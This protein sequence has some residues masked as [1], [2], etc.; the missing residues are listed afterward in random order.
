MKNY[1]VL[2]SH[3]ENFYSEPWIYINMDQ[4]N[5]RVFLTNRSGAV[6]I[7]NTEVIL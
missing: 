2:I 6:Y 3:L 4:K 1:K 5:Q 7:I